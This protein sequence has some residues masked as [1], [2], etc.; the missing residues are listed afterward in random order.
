[1]RVIELRGDPEDILW[2]RSVMLFPEDSE[3]RERAFSVEFA[4]EF[5]ADVDRQKFQSLNRRTVELLIEAP[6]Y[7]DLKKIAAER[8][9]KAILA[10]NL[11]MAVFL[12]HRFN[13]PEPS[14]NKARFVAKEFAARARYGDGSAIDKSE[15][16]INRAWNDFRSVAHLWAAFEINK[17][18]PFAPKREIFTPNFLP[19][20]LGVAAEILRFGE[21]F[22]PK[23]ARP[24]VPIVDAKTAWHLPDSVEPIALANPSRPPILLQKTLKKYRAET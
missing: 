21:S 12:M 8:T 1:M 23:R 19:S 18:Y 13:E 5:L 6:A 24:H 20:F 7:S 4:R 3:L 11:L 2:V 14:L 10:G 16:S 22:I 9:K 17:A 15:P